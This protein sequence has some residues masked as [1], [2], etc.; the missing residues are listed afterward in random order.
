V[1]HAEEVERPEHRI[2]LAALN[3]AKRMAGLPQILPHVD[4][5]VAA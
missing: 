5:R 3:A 4:G 2:I 1:D